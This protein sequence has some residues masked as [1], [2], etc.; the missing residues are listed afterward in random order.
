MCLFFLPLSAKLQ[1]DGWYSAG[2]EPSPGIRGCYWQHIDGH[3][4]REKI[5]KA[6]AQRW[7]VEIVRLRGDWPILIL[8]SAAHNKWSETALH[9]F[10]FVPPPPVPPPPAH[11]LVHF[12]RFTHSLLASLHTSLFSSSFF[13]G[14]PLIRVDTLWLHR[15]LEPETWSSTRQ[16]MRVCQHQ[17]I[18]TR[19][20]DFHTVD[21]CVCVCEFFC[22]H[23]CPGFGNFLIGC[24]P[25]FCFSLPQRP[26]Q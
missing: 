23:H 21:V 19:W 3:R 26:C 16:Y 12:N 17:W 11:F 10:S 22:T 25:C 18:T 13:F 1:F 24:F 4:E 20:R 6:Q 2:E 7:S 15:R 9:H 8:S 5:G 14:F